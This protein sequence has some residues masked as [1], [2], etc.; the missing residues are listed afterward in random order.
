MNTSHI[1]LGLSKLALSS[2]KKAWGWLFLS[3]FTLPVMAQ[4]PSDSLMDEAEYRFASLTQLWHNTNNASGLSLDD[5]SNRGFASVGFSHRGGDYHRVQ[6]GG[7][8]E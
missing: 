7:S 6:E 1:V 5:S 8:N 3:L 4:T 2:L